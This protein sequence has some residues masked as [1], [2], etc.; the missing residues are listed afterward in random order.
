MYFLPATGPGAGVPWKSTGPNPNFYKLELK[1][2]GENLT[3]QLSVPNGIS[4]VTAVDVN[5]DD[6]ADYVYA[7]DRFGNVWKIDVTSASPGNWAS[8]FGSAGAPLPLFT[9]KDASGNRQQITTGFS[10]VPN[11]NGGYIINFGTGSWVDI[12]DAVGPYT[13]VDSLYGIWDTMASSEVPISSRA[14][15]QQQEPLAHVTIDS[16]GTVTG[17]CSAGDPNC[18]VVQS[19]CSVNYG[20]TAVATNAGNLCPS[21]IAHGNSQGTQYGWFMDYVGTGERTRST[22]PLVNGGVITVQSVTPSP[23][24]CTGNTIGMEYQVSALTGGEPALPVYIVSSGNTQSV[25]LPL[26][27]L[28]ISGGAS[29]QIN[30]SGQSVAGGASDN[31]VQFNIRPPSSGT[32]STPVTPC[33]AND[34]NLLNPPIP[35]YP[36]WGY[37]DQLNS[38][39][40]YVLACHQP[41]FGSGNP[42]CTLE[43]KQ[44]HYGELSW[45]LINR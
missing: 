41:E 31:P 33:F 42:V 30:P 26:A 40:F 35:F 10:A 24:P 18:Y 19:N 3:S 34:C 32:S 2:P 36:G 9:A 44:G 14:L 27:D 13:T 7:G 5:G 11:P 45:K 17:L 39:Q 16:T 28:G 20:S 22:V 23:N 37:A 43:S 8:A 21:S 38:K 6:V 4:G 29:I 15:L 1:S 12:Q 25:S